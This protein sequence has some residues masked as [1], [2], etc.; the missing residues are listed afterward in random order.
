MKAKSGVGEFLFFK[1]F[2]LICLSAIATITRKVLLRLY[3]YSE[4]VWLVH[5][6]YLLVRV[7]FAI[8]QRSIFQSLWHWQCSFWRRWV[9]WLYKD[10]FL[11]C[12]LCEKFIIGWCT[13]TSVM[14]FA[15]NGLHWDHIRSQSGIF[16]SW[17]ISALSLAVHKCTD[18]PA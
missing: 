5:H 2:I 17:I 15:T 13:L 8:N 1:K 9:D 11:P 4:N 6:Y 14:A 10:L 12:L 7:R 16:I 3:L 18:Q